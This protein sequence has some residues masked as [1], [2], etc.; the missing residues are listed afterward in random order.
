MPFINPSFLKKYTLNINACLVTVLLIAI[1][2]TVQS[3]FFTMGSDPASLRWNQIKTEHFTII[4]PENL[5]QKAQ[6]IANG[7][8]YFYLPGSA[9]LNTRTPHMPV[10]LH[11]QS[12][13]SNA[14]VPY[15]PR[16]IE[17]L[18]T[19]PQDNYA[20][21]WVDQLILHEFRH[22]AQYSAINRGLTLGL[23]Y[24]FGQLAVPVVFGMFVPFWFIEGDGTINETAFSQSGRGRVPAFEMRMKAQFLEKG[25]YHYDKA[26]HGSY[27]DFTP[28]R[29]EL[30]YQLVGRTRVEFGRDV[31]ANALKKTGSLPIMIVPFSY[32]LKKQTGFGK[33]PLYRHITGQMQDEWTAA[34]Q[35]MELTPVHPLTDGS[36]HYTNYIMPVILPD[37]SI[38]AIKKSMDDITRI[39]RI[40]GSQ[41]E[42]FLTPG[43]GFFETSMTASGTLLCWGEVKPDPRWQFRDYAVIMTLDLQTGEI[44]QA[45]HQSRLFAPAINRQGDRIVTVEATPESRYALV[46]L[47]LADGEETA[48]FLTPDNLF[49]LQPAWSEDGKKIVSIVLGDN[50]KS[51]ILWDPATDSSRFL[52]PFTHTEISRPS[53]HGDHILFCGAYSGTDN[54]HA[55][56]PHTGEVHQLTSA[57][58]GARDAVAVSGSD[59][60]VY[61]HY[62]SDGYQLARLELDSAWWRAHPAG[63][64]TLFPL[65]EALAE[66]EDFIFHPDS[67]PDQTFPVKRYRKGLH[68]FNIHSW[69]PLAF[70]IDSRE[71][72]PGASLFSQNLLGTS[73]ASLNYEYDL[74]EEASTWSFD[75]TYEGFYPSLYLGWEYGLRRGLHTDDLGNTTQFKFH[76]MNY[77]AGAGIPLSWSVRSWYM[78]TSAGLGFSHRFLYMDPESDLKFRHD[79]ILSPNYR[80]F[81]YAQQKTSLRDLQPRWG[82]QLEINFGHTLFD[83]ALF[84]NSI[85]SAEGAFFFPGMIRHHGLRIYSGYQERNVDY[86]RFASEIRTARGHTGIFSDAMATLS[87]DYVFPIFYPDWRIGPVFYLKRLSG[88]LFYDHTL[89]MDQS[90]HT[91]YN[92]IG[93]DLTL[94]LHFLSI[95]APLE[96]GVR[97]M[98][99]PSQ[100]GVSFEAIYYTDFDS[101]Y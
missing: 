4:F 7:F 98:Y 62:T 18:M 69:A 21:R 13:R 15:A 79:Q 92:T 50:G 14:F 68:L 49:F 101:L 96:I 52:L 91:Y 16:R 60:L 88:R 41:E 19:P 33:V 82:Q 57:R 39:V 87:A 47:S 73:Y 86:Y 25:I 70:N 17:F 10:L 72:K 61:S 24:A 89:L 75:Y 46:V 53:F 54:I 63:Q 81:F 99:F 71:A 29:Y 38:L 55:L 100:G 77:S 28:D 66:Q 34:G 3:Q 26:T 56:S 30:G 48:R 64:K 12:V 45:T 5:E 85:F 31:W 42:V 44:R 32:S 9:S 43:T 23:S 27:K 93:M 37:G 36:K 95:L 35:D 11:S 20:H 6:Y 84:S 22:A 59:A 65:A 80:F 1:S 67:V 58:F 51:M 97:A 83:S 8:E 2:L 74:N 40:T 76:E 90:P 78:G 94:N